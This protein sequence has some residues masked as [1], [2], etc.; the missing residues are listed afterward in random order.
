MEK[1]EEFWEFERSSG[2]AGYRNKKT[3]EWIYKED[4]FRRQKTKTV[5]ED[6]KEEKEADDEKKDDTETEKETD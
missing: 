1:D 2:Y 4:Y 3:G 6:K 5:E